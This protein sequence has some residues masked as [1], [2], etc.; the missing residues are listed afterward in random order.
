MKEITHGTIAIG[1]YLAVLWTLGFIA[2]HGEVR[3]YEYNRV[4]LAAEIVLV[5][6]A[7][8]LAVERFRDDIRTLR[9]PK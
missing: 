6:L 4:I 5:V 8:V 7:L 3:I 9:G 1:I 2:W